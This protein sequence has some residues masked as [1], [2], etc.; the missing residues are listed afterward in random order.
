MSPSQ[1]VLSVVVGQPAAATVAATLNCAKSAHGTVRQHG[2]VGRS[3]W[4]GRCMLC[5]CRVRFVDA[6]AC[7]GPLAATSRC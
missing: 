5:G 7:L 3:A 2:R 1:P 6:Y 4:Q